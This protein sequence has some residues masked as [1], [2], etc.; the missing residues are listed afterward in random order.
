ME[1][2]F[3][4]EAQTRN[5]CVAEVCAKL[6][7]T[8]DM[9]E[10]RLDET[11]EDV[12]ELTLK[13]DAVEKGSEGA[14]SCEPGAATLRAEAIEA[15]D[16]RKVRPSQSTARIEEL[17]EEDGQTTGTSDA[18][19]L[20]KIGKARACYDKHL[21]EVEQILAE[22]A[23][24]LLNH[25]LQPSLPEL[26]EVDGQ[27]EE[28]VAQA[29]AHFE[30]L[31]CHEAPTTETGLIEAALRLT[32]AKAH[33]MEQFGIV[34]ADVDEKYAADAT[35]VVECH[36]REPEAETSPGCHELQPNFGQP[37]N[38]E[39]LTGRFKLPN[40]C[41]NEAIAT[42]EG[43]VA[44]VTKMVENGLEETAA[45]IMAA[46]SR[47]EN[48]AVGHLEERLVDVFA[49]V[50]EA[51]AGTSS[52]DSSRS[53]EFEQNQISLERRVFMVERRLDNRLG[54]ARPVL[55]SCLPTPRDHS[56]PP[57]DDWGWTV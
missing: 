51:R 6:N 16:V 40:E 57:H 42:L 24:K 13:L 53:R 31:F 11:R 21:G 8:R 33:L 48:T 47:I 19:V 49:L 25:T 4:K 41:L 15:D 2:L 37:K 39:L 18:P 9:L 28:R 17:L 56:P 20:E 38:Q 26:P 27:L 50:A 44:D 55:T 12:A 22:V 3:G 35:K 30:E 14:A 43:R 46:E 45:K 36:S 23:T 5:E 32:D 29:T 10:K 1:E 54:V 7:E 52:V 34:M